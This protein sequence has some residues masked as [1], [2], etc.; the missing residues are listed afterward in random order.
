MSE[1]RGL[2]RWPQA[3]GGVA[4]AALGGA[5]L[6][7]LVLILFYR[8]GGLPAV[9]PPVVLAGAELRLASGQGGQTAAGLEIRQPGPQGLAAV[10]GSARLVRAALYRRLSWRVDGLEPGREVR[11]VWSTLADP[12]TVRELVLPSAGPDGGTLDLGAEPRWQ[13]RI[14]VIGLAVRGP[15][16]QPLVIHHLELRPPVLGVGELLRWAV[17]EWTVFEDWSQRSINYTAGAPLDALFPPV[18]VVALWVGFSAALYAA[19][20]P[21]RLGGGPWWPYAALFLLGWLALDARWQWDLSRRLEQTVERFAGKEGDERRLA[22]TDGALY[23]FLREVRWRLPERPARLFIVSA[24][25]HDGTAYQAGRARY[26]LL[27]HNGYTGLSQPPGIGVARAGDYVLILSP[28]SGVRYDRERRTLEWA[29]G[30][31][32]ADM[33]HAAAAGALFRV[34]GA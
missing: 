1:P 9:A 22:G 12:R 15:L 8:A 10:Q 18:L 5:L 24:D 23:R 33:L 27:P 20:R 34:R 19:F 4:L 7:A 3:V 32:P 29:N 26:H 14:A 31:L 28:L 2:G 13:G 6:A 16:P 25:P 17:E 30:R 21:P 11:L